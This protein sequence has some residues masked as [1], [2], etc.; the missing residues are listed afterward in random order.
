MKFLGKTKNFH[1]PLPEPVYFE[2][3]EAAENMQKP[4]T[5]MVRDMIESWLIKRRKA[6][7]NQE[8][9]TYVEAHAGTQFDIDPELEAAGCEHL[10]GQKKKTRRGFSS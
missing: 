1:V 10:L 7:L 5:Q 3:R 9:K 6:K 4:A 2:L 8:L